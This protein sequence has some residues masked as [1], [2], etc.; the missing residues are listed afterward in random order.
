MRQRV[1]CARMRVGDEGSEYLW[2]RIEMLW[3]KERGENRGEREGQ[4]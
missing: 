4:G 3:L 1:T 2:E